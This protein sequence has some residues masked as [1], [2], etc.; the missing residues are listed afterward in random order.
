MPKA[1]ALPRGIRNNNPGNIEYNFKNPVPWQNLADPPHDGRF[2]RFKTPPDGIRAMCKVLITYQDK[3]K[4]KDGSKIDTVREIIERWAPASENNVP[5]YTASVRNAMGLSGVEEDGELDVHDY[6]AMLPLV[7]GIIRHEN[8]MMPY[9]DL[10]LDK[11]L[12]MA[13][14][15]P[16]TE[17]ESLQKSGVVRG[18]Q[19]TTIG[20]IGGGVAGIG[21]IAELADQA[22]E[23]ADHLSPLVYY[24]KWIMVAFVGL[25]LAGIG[26]SFY[27]KHRE[28]EQGVG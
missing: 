26:L 7:K 28:R 20:T 9:T 27:A 12:L 6:R 17:T 10:Q 3:R 25:S 16:P 8:G 11:G 18:G 23:A 5:A 4:A 1:T 2:C 14:I 19:I 15:H 24:G 22:R 13:G 21:T